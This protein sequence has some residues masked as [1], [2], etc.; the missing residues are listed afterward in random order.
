MTYVNDVKLI[1]NFTLEDEFA[2]Q[3]ELIQ[4]INSAL[5]NKGIV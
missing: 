4:Q 2:E 5:E 3:T 1:G